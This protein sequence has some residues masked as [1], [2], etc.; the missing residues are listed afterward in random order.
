MLATFTHTSPTAPYASG[1]ALPFGARGAKEILDPEDKENSNIP[2]DA[3]AFNFFDSL[4]E[5]RAL[6][7]ACEVTVSARET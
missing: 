3:Q 1:V 4:Y 7:N 2:A 5:F 6:S